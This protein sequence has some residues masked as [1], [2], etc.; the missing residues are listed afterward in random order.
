MPPKKQY[1]KVKRV[2]IRDMFLL[3]RVDL[4]DG[5]RFQVE[6]VTAACAACRRVSKRTHWLAADNACPFCGC[7]DSMVFDGRKSLTRDADPLKAA[8]ELVKRF[9]ECLQK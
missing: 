5:K 9:G 1:L 2:S 3:S 7:P 8:A 4:M 6:D